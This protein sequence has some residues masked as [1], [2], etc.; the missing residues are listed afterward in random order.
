MPKR[1]ALIREETDRPELQ[2]FVLGGDEDTR[3]M[4]VAMVR[5]ELQSLHAEMKMYPV[6][7]L[8]LT[9]GGEQW[10]SVSRQC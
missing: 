9:G 3:R 2:A 1:P 10:I 7:E 8:E 5:R 6:E 4:L